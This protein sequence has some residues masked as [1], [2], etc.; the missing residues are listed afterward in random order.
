MNPYAQAIEG[1]TAARINL[2][3]DFKQ[4]KKSLDVPKDLRKKNESGFTNEQAVRVYLWNKANKEVPG[5]SK[6]D[7]K[8]L[9][10]AIENKS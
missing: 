2:M 9:N 1:L 4:L 3:E 8:E 7:L 6:R 10:D 5:L